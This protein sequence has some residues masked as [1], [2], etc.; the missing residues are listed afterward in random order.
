MTIKLQFYK[1]EVCGNIVEVYGAGAGKL[2]CC[3]Q[4]MNLLE[5]KSEDAGLEKHVPVVE[6]AG[7][8]VNVKVGD[9]PHPMEENH[10]IQWIEVI[11]KNGK[12]TKFLKPNTEPAAEFMMTEDI[13][14][15]RE[16]CNVH[17]LWS[18]KM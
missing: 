2:V 6:V 15:V 13:I 18:K 7:E 9:V 5:E 4:A 11:T 3:G 8:K 17:G 14:E 1:C 10:F 12:C 16:L